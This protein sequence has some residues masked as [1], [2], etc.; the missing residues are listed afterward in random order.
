MSEIPDPGQCLVCRGVILDR[1]SSYV[2]PHL[3]PFGVCSANGIHSVEEAERIREQIAQRLLA[4]RSPLTK[5][6]EDEIL[7]ACSDAYRRGYED[8]RRAP[9]IARSPEAGEASRAVRASGQA[10]IDAFHAHLD[11]CA[12]CREHPFDLC[13]KGKPLLKAAA[14]ADTGTPPDAGEKRNEEG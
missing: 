11:A 3:V 2:P 9:P 13:A 5:E 14:S 8:G 6:D 10:R 12:W 1:N 7:A 4:A